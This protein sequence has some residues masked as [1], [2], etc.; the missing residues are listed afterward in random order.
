[1]TTETSQPAPASSANL[2]P[3]QLRPMRFEDYE[4][5]HALESSQFLEHQPFSD[6]QGFW[7]DNPLWPRLADRWPLGWVLEAPGGKLVGTMSN[8]PSL[9]K[10]RGQDLICANG[11]AWFVLPEYRGF[12]LWPMDEYF[13]QPGVDLY[14]NTTVGPL[15]VPAVSS[16]AERIP[17]GDWETAA[18][19]ATSYTDLA[20]RGLEKSHLP[21][22][23]FLALPLAAGLW[24]K[25]AIFVPTLPGP[26]PGVEVACVKEFDAHFD[27]FWTELLARNPDKLLGVRDR[28]ALSWHY[29]RPI[30]RDRLRVFTASRN[31]LLRAF[32]VVKRQDF[33]DGLKRLRLVDFQTIEPDIDLLPGLLRAALRRGAEEGFAVLEHLGTGV[34]RMAT[35]DR[36]APYRRKMPS[37]PF[38]WQAAETALRLELRS[39]A[40]WDASTYDGD[41]S[42]E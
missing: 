21:Q 22:T 24:L 34:P 16:Y 2:A 28:A 40:V 23:S 10:F 17:G 1:M 9:Y 3:P 39:P 19:F 36:H 15:A 35:F 30:R 11:R 25:D 29:A 14:I 8:V 13:R 18:Y 7:R 37:W 27:T 5:V 31:G 42:Y 32:C 20:R 38:Y 33:G 4:Q 12:A 6:W 41:A 26:P